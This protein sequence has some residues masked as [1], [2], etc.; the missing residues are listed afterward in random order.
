MY[1][2]TVMLRL[3]SDPATNRQYVTATLTDDDGVDFSDAGRWSL[4]Y[5]GDDST[6][7]TAHVYLTVVGE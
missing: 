3:L 6:D 2:Q 7:F 5:T 1:V 4:H